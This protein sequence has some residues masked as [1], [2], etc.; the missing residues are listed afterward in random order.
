VNFVISAD[1]VAERTKISRRYLEAIEEGG[2]IACLARPL[3]GAIR[4]YAQSVGLDPKIPLIYNH[5]RMVHDGVTAGRACP[6]TGA[7]GMNASAVAF[8]GGGGCCGGARER[9]W[10]S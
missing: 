8:G 5:S 3:C 9:R 1:D 2:M 6:Q 10:P 4:S 7:H